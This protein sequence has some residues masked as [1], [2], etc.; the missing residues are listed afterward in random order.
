MKYKIIL[1]KMN[2]EI[3]SG[4]EAEIL[5]IN[6]IIILRPKKQITQEKYESIIHDMRK[7][8]Q[9]DRNKMQILFIPYDCDI[10][11][12]EHLKEG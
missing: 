7:T 4:Q 5:N 1:K 3:I 8:S 9:V 2:D 6:N 10:L 11:E 12:L